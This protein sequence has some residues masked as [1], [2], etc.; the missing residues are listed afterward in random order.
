MWNS[1]AFTLPDFTPYLVSAHLLLLLQA[2][3]GACQ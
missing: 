2:N 1:S 3:T